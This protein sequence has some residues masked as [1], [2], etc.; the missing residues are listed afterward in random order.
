LTGDR[1]AILGPPLSGKTSQ[2]RLIA[3]EFGLQHISTGNIFRQEIEAK[4]DLGVK[5]YDWIVSGSLVPDEIVLGVFRR[6]LKAAEGK[7]L[8]DGFPRTITQAR[9]LEEYLATVKATLDHMIILDVPDDVVITRALKR[10]RE[11]HRPEDCSRN[12]LLK[13]LGLYRQQTMKAIEF[14]DRL[15]VVSHVDGTEHVDYVFE[16]TRKLVVNGISVH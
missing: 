8:L 15:G 7:F 12:V 3:K 2:A 1:L 10:R 16:Q 13:R 5:I 9:F 11:E 4:S 6:Y 14:F